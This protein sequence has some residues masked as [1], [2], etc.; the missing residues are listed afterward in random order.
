MATA[1][2]TGRLAADNIAFPAATREP[3]YAVVTKSAG[4]RRSTQSRHAELREAGEALSALVR[5]DAGSP[6]DMEWAAIYDA[7]RVDFGAPDSP[8]MVLC[9]FEAQIAVS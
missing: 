3:R 8:A 4:A 9:V 2:D 7:E 6:E 5:G 1:H